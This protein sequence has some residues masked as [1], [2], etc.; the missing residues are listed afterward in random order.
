MYYISLATSAP[1]LP[2]DA[3][4]KPD[5]EEWRSFMS[6][7]GSAIAAWQMVESSLTVLYLEAINPTNRA[8]ANAA[9][10]T[11]AG[12]NNRLNMTNE[13]VRLAFTDEQTI[14][15]WDN[16]YSH[17]KKRTSKRNLIAHSIVCFDEIA[18]Q[19]RR[20]FLVNGL[21]DARNRPLNLAAQGAR[22]YEKELVE[23][24]SSFGNLQGE[25]MGFWH[26]TFP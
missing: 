9:F 14:G 21:F 6:T 4:P 19:P 10:H 23:I 15:K 7:F 2:P 18:E 5:E 3:L 17:C 25:I 24:A 20:L 12:F 8:A 22:T 1:T 13:A 16:I 11:I 26:S